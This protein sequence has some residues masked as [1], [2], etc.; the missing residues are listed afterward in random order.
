MSQYI[1]GERGWIPISRRLPD[2]DVAVLVAAW[3]GKVV[4]MDAL[5]EN[6]KWIKGENENI[7]DWMPLPESPAEAARKQ[8]GQPNAEVPVDE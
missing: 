7:T 1:D 5:F 8:P 6:G 3:G 4:K 2:P